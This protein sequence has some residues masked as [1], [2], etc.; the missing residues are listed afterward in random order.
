[1]QSVTVDGQPH[2]DFDPRTETVTLTPTSAKAT[3]HVR[4]QY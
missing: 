1:M 3:M 4:V 2:Q